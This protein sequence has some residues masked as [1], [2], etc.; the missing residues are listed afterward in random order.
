[1]LVLRSFAFD[2]CV[3]CWAPELTAATPDSTSRTAAAGF[4]PEDHE[5]MASIFLFCV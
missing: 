4:T 1:M 3:K 2:C 5:G